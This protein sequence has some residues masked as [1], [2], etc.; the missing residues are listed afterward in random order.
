MSKFKNF[1]NSLL[2]SKNKNKKNLRA[3]DIEIH[4]KNILYAI[5]TEAKS[6][7]I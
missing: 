3:V 1:L 2:P 7:Y 4:F 6:R 5:E